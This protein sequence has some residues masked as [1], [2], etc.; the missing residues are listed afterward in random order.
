MNILLTSKVKTL[1]LF[2]PNIKFISDSKKRLITNR[3]KDTLQNF[4]ENAKV[5]SA[6]KHRNTA[7]GIIIHTEFTLFHW[8]LKEQSIILLLSFTH[9]L[10]LVRRLRFLFMLNS[11]LIEATQIWWLWRRHKHQTKFREFIYEEILAYRF[12]NFVCI[13][14]LCTIIL[15]FV[16][17]SWPDVHNNNSEECFSHVLTSLTLL[18]KSTLLLK[19]SE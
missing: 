18:H 2:C 4:A 3:M 8:S 1:V 17:I 9:L 16:Q 15:K 14:G 13:T 11:Y 7:K 6:T 12:N 19:T 5:A 10:A